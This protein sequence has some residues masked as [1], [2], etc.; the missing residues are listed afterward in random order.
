MA[1]RLFL[2]KRGV[3]LIL[4]LI[5]KLDLHP[6]KYKDVYRMMQRP[7]AYMGIDE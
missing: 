5:N 4:A 6:F 7:V 3:L 2:I 1:V